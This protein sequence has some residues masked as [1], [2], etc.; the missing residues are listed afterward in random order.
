MTLTKLIYVLWLLPQ[1]LPREA[2]QYLVEAVGDFEVLRILVLAHLGD[3]I[4]FIHR[5]RCLHC[6]YT[7]IRCEM[8][9]L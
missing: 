3:L 4:R 7:Q 5:Y 9:S 2:T 1:Y 8:M 6:L